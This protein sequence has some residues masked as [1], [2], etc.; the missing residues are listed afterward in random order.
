MYY[1]LA[2]RRNDVVRLCLSAGA[3]P[4]LRFESRHSLESCF[5]SNVHWDDAI[6]F[7]PWLTSHFGELRKNQGRYSIEH[8]Y[9]QT[10]AYQ[11]RLS[12]TN[13]SFRSFKAF[14]WTPLHVAALRNDVGLL[15]LLLDHGANPNSSGRGVCPCYYQRVR[16]TFKRSAP[17]DS[18]EMLE[19]RLVTRWSPL[20]V[21]VCKG[22][23]DCAQYLISGFG[24]AR[25]IESDD[26]VLAQARQFFLEEQRLEDL[27]RFPETINRL[28][29]RFDPLS[30]LHVAAEKYAS[31]EDLE[32][33]YL[34]LEQAECLGGTPPK[35]DILD[36]FGD[37][38]FAV[39]AFSGRAETFGTWFRARDADVNFALEDADGVRRSIL[40]GLCKSGQHGDALFL[41]DLGVDVNRDAKLHSGEDHESALHLCCGWRGYES[42][43][44]TEG[45]LGKQRDAIALLKRL[46]HAGA[47]VNARA[48]NGTTALMSAAKLNFPAAVREVLKGKPDI[49]AED[50]DG[51]SAL[52]YAAAQAQKT[53]VGPLL[54][55]ALLTMQLLLDHGADPNHKRAGT[56]PPPLFTGRYGI[57]AGCGAL[58]KGFSTGDRTIDGSQHPM[59]SIA[60]LLITRGADPNIYLDH[61]RD[62]GN[63]LDQ[64]IF[65]LHGHSLAVTAFYE[66]EFDSLDSLVAC[67]TIVTYQDYLLMMRALANPHVRSKGGKSAAVQSL[68]R[69]LNSPS[70]RLERPGDRERIMDAWTELLYLAVGERPR[71]VHALAPHLSV[72]NRLGLGGKT[73]LHLFAQW[74]RKRGEMTGETTAGFRSRVNR[75]M[76]DLMLCGVGRQIDQLDDSGRSPL[77]IAVDRDN[78]AVAKALVQ[79]GASLHL[80]RKQP[81]GSTADSPLRS[82]I[83]D[84]SQARR[85]RVADGM[86]DA[87]HVHFGLTEFGKKLERY[88]G[89]AGLLKDLILHFRDATFDEPGRMAART[90][91][92][93][94]KL[95]DHGVD[96]NE[97]D[98]DGN[99]ALHLLIQ[100]LYPPKQDINKSRRSHRVNLSKKFGDAGD[101]SESPTP[102]EE[103]DPE[104]VFW[105]FQ[106]Q[107][108]NMRG[109]NSMYNSDSD[110]VWKESDDN[111][112]DNDG[113]DSDDYSEIGSPHDTYV[114]FEDESDDSYNEEDDRSVMIFNF[115]DDLRVMAKNGDETEFP[116]YLPSGLAGR[117]R[118][119]QLDRCDAWILSFYI[120]LFE[121]GSLNIKNNAGKTALD[122]MKGLGVCRS[123]ACSKACSKAYHR[124]MTAVKN[125]DVLAPLDSELFTKLNGS[126][127]LPKKG[128]PF[129]F[130]YNRK[131]CFL[132]VPR[133][134]DQRQVK[135]WDSKSISKG[136][137]DWNWLPFW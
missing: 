97:P 135:R 118:D 46:V 20:H 1:G 137:K 56:G 106:E 108:R 122:Y 124:I 67:G 34:M 86:L 112:T 72:T 27:S 47:D 26:A 6:N 113:N 39:V 70:L 131:N 128:R 11:Y 132:V 110:Y 96:V 35:V 10:G 78:V 79:S 68:F 83:K 59:A 51:Y 50:H 16:R 85:F 119:R 25:S 90:N 71:L 55:A 52:H 42:D 38:P 66:G 15:A 98:E 36:A 37:T 116:R 91:K 13:D 21:S 84:Y 136:L 32:R 60:P 87:H 134:E 2:T 7:F 41:I 127:V 120:L 14:Y 75:T 9:P 69:L 19:R 95:I 5:P 4:D 12:H 101:K 89:S 28:T 24:L 64:Q 61:P 82:A 33:L 121:G 104:R 133:E 18:I 30:P 74:G 80:E 126:S 92:L 123:K 58:T 48:E 94:M 40:N 76:A 73:A 100:V 29:P 43:W 125:F 105:I 54:S 129:F 107:D 130:A 57:G 93:I 49:K 81:D 111:D 8:I 88:C 23:F 3:D 44:P 117:G 65:N 31:V 45:K 62:L 63:G 109:E 99:T 22:N 115:P 53:A 17:E 102:P 114:V 77:H 103:V